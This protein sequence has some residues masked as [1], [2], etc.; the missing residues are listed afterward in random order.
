MIL[1]DIVNYK[2][3]QLEEEKKQL[4]L[5]EFEHKIIDIATRDFK[6]SLSKDRISIIAEI[7]KA[8]PSKGVIKA[9]FNAE[10]IGKVYEKINIDAISILTEKEFFKGK[11]EYIRLVEAVTTKPLLRKDFIVD[12]YQIFQA[13]YIGADA[14]LLIVS[15]LKGKL[16]NFYKLAKELGLQC[17]VEVHNRE[18]LEIALEAEAD[19]I[20]VN[21][22]NLKDFT[23]NIKNTEELIKFVPKDKIIV[24]ESGIKNAEDILYLNSIGAKAALIGETF[25][26]NIENI[27]L[28]ND[29]IAK[30]KGE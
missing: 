11:D 18:E 17:L 9:D 1:E 25:M 12:E 16:K 23:V 21:N 26:R 2:I 28:V 29:F 30:A 5:Y 4:P 3:K 10:A 27:E 8:S 7:K 24:S 20:G 14:I 13:K 22:R 6:A 15:V 19:I